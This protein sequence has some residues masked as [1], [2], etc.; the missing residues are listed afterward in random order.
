M[1]RKFTKKRAKKLTEDQE[2]EIVND[3][4]SN[5]NNRTE[6]VMKRTGF[7]T[8]QVDN[9]INKYLYKRGQW[10]KND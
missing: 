8:Y 6:D 10:A 5:V 1:G 9:A 4:L 7:G 2:M 3:F